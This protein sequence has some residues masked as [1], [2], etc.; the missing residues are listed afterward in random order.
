MVPF[1]IVILSASHVCNVGRGNKKNYYQ[2]QMVLKCPGQFWTRDQIS[3]ICYT[4]RNSHNQRI[5]VHDIFLVLVLTSIIKHNYTKTRRTVELYICNFFIQVRGSSSTVNGSVD[6]LD[7][8]QWQPITECQFC[9]INKV[10]C[11]CSLSMF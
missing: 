8:C 7:H 3:I 6:Q 4:S 2:T 5:L 1:L 10:T 11:R 9:Q